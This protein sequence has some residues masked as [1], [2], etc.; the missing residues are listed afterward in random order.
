MSKL[1]VLRSKGYEEIEWDPGAAEAGETE[2]VEAAEK[3]RTAMEDEQSRGGAAFEV[4]GPGRR[5]QR[6]ETFDPTAEQIVVLPAEL[7]TAE[8][9]AQREL[10]E[11]LL[12]VANPVTARPLAGMATALAR[13]GGQAG[14][15]AVK[16]VPFPLTIPL[17][18]A[19]GYVER[20]GSE[21]APTLRQVATCT[22]NAEVEVDLLLRAAHGVASGIVAVAESGPETGLILL[23]WPGPRT[24]APVSPSVGEQVLREAPCDVAL[25]LNRGVDAVRRV[26]V[27]LGDSPHDPLALHL[28]RCVAQGEDASLVVL[29]VSPADREGEVEAEEAALREMLHDI[30][31][32]SEGHV[33]LRVACSDSVPDAIVEEAEKGYDLLVMGAAPE[34]FLPH[35]LFGAVPDIVAERAPCSVLLA[36][37]HSAVESSVLGRIAAWLQGSA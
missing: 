20:G 9:A 33:S 29:G 30:L 19:Q 28:A 1:I 6:L 13:G 5:A 37:K 2:A 3:A 21:Q 14:V 18:V 34:S 17:S 11:I 4:S 31:E 15:A 10:G 23:G 35:W 12:A 8:G 16:I 25:F 24:L 27:P 36:K 7:A 22:A 32:A 26:L